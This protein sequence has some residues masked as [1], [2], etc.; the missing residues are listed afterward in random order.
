MVSKDASAGPSDNVEQ[1]MNR[2]LQAEQE[3]GKAIADC[4]YEARQIL[5]VAQQR[6]KRIA[7]RTDER[8][9]LIHMRLVRKSKAQIEALEHADRA[10]QHEPSVYDLDEAALAAVVQ[11]VAAE[12][13]GT[14]PPP[15]G[16]REKSGNE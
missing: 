1:A 4:E 11:E 8:I 2:V 6:V 10:A 3:A 14:R 13:T 16:R 7:D 5:Q 15:G 12:L 9:A